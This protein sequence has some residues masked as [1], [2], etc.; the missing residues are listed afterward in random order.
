MGI[1]S[2]LDAGHVYRGDRVRERCRRK[3]RKQTRVSPG[4]QDELSAYNSRS[5]ADAK[6]FRAL[7][8]FHGFR[9]VD[10]YVG[11]TPN[12]TWVRPDMLTALW[13]LSDLSKLAL[14]GRMVVHA[15]GLPQCGRDHT[16]QDDVGL[17]GT[18][19]LRD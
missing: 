4:M 10:A 14:A 18:K 11:A 6:V 5:D 3:R 1:A 7:N 16:H 19:S 12:S 2:F 9:T 13:Y 15:P 17:V 8:A